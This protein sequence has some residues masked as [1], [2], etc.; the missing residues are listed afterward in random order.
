MRSG[1]PILSLPHVV[2]RRVSKSWDIF[3]LIK[4]L[5]LSSEDL[6]KAVKLTKFE[7]QKVEVEFRKDYTVDVIVWFEGKEHTFNLIETMTEKMVPEFRQTSPLK[8]EIHYQRS[9]NQV[10][11][12]CKSILDLFRKSSIDRFQFSRN[13]Y[14]SD[15][16]NYSNIIVDAKS[17]HVSPDSVTE[18]ELDLIFGIFQKL[19]NLSLRN[20]LPKNYKGLNNRKLKFLRVPSD[21]NGI[22]DFEVERLWLPKTLWTTFEFNFYIKH[23]LKAPN[24]CLKEVHVMVMEI[25]NIFD[26]L[27]TNAW[28]PCSRGKYFISEDG[29]KPTAINCSE[30]LDIVREDGLMATVTLEKSQV[31]FYVWHQKF[32]T[33]PKNARMQQKL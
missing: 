20:R 17:V 30:G 5:E 28:N 4:L 11:K 12:I 9:Q 3:D 6:K 14:E 31:G 23:W 33:V 7:T 32:P 29:W 21:W 27:T 10:E 2:F 19:E 24:P 22:K 8:C 25:S 16:K 1:F 26:G 18:E 15:F 13:I